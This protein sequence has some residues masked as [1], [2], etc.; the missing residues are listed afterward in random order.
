MLFVFS[1]F[2]RDM[3]RILIEDCSARANGVDLGQKVSIRSRQV[4][5]LK[6]SSKS[7]TFADH[8][9]VTC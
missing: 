2:E 1:E 5:A 9:Y 6:K 3:I 7:W 4:I 8:R